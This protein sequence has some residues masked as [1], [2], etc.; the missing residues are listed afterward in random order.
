MKTTQL[1]D[2]SSLTTDPRRNEQID[3]LLFRIESE[4]VDPGPAAAPSVTV[5]ADTGQALSELRFDFETTSD[6]N[7]YFII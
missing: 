2:L 4:L 6:C 1:V 3:R 7:C 5:T